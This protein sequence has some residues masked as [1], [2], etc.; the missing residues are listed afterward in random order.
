M[1]IRK[2]ADRD[3]LIAKGFQWACVEPRGENKGQV[4]SRHKSYEAANKKAH[5]K[6]WK[7]VNIADAN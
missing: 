5:G 2:Q 6:E 4:I 3:A 1:N 7:I